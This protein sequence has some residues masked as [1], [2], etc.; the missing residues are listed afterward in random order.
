M[1]S[2]KSPIVIMMYFFY[3]HWKVNLY[4][5]SCT[6]LFDTLCER[7]NSLCLALACNLHILKYVW[8]WDGIIQLLLKAITL[9][10]RIMSIFL[11]QCKHGYYSI[12]LKQTNQITKRSYNNCPP[13]SLLP[14]TNFHLALILPLIYTPTTIIYYNFDFGRNSTLQYSSYPCPL[15][16]PIFYFYYHPLEKC[17][18]RLFYKLLASSIRINMLWWKLIGIF[19]FHA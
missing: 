15:F 12:K 11:N 18:T 6:V 5:S 3:R 14:L 7:Y 1:N 17:K 13:P 4:Y 8:V 16:L 19:N 9:F 2:L 10:F